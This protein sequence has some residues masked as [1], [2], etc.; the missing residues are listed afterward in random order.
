MRRDLTAAELRKR[1]AAAERS[2]HAWASGA[3]GERLVAQALGELETHGWHLLHDLHWPGRR[4]ANLDHVAVGPGGVVVVDAKKWSGTVRISDGHLRQN[5]YRRDRELEGV[6]RATAAVAALLPPEHRASTRG[7]LCLVDQPVRPTRTRSGV[8]VVGRAYLVHHL[9]SLDATLTSDDVDRL[10]HLLRAQL[11]GPRS[12]A[13]TTTAAVEVATPARREPPAR[14]RV[15]LRP[16]PR[17]RRFTSREL[18]GLAF[19]L[20]VLFVSAMILTRLAGGLLAGL[21]APFAPT[22]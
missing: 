22:G 5:G 8:P 6:A 1:L 3:E 13:L 10:T 9:R 7:L 20:V 19:A 16:P 2:H 18:A 21:A 15:P 11:D 12:P 14:R 4:S 17:P